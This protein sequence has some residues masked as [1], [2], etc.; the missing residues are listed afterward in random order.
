MVH[1]VQQVELVKYI[2]KN[3]I[4]YL[5]GRRARSRRRGE[6]EPQTLSVSPNVHVPMDF[7]G[8]VSIDFDYF[9]G[10]MFRVY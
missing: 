9:S 10:F 4:R 8:P 1:L 3:A 5:S 2:M 7:T 6:D